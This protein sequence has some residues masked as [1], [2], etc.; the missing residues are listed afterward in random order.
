MGG[1][2]LSHSAETLTRR[3]AHSEVHLIHG[4]FRHEFVRRELGEAFAKRPGFLGKICLEGNQDRSWR[5]GVWRIRTEANEVN[6][7]AIRGYPWLK[8]FVSLSLGCSKS[9]AIRVIRE[10]RDSFR[11]WC[12][13]SRVSGFGSGNGGW[14]I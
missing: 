7:A 10:I 14:L 9:A 12:L 6:E 8:F 2:H 5:I 3:P 1:V 4:K 11:V 13:A